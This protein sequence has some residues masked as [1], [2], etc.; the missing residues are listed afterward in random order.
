MSQANYKMKEKK[1]EH[2]DTAANQDDHNNYLSKLKNK[3]QVGM[4]G[5]VKKVTEE[6]TEVKASQLTT[7]TFK[8]MTSRNSV[9]ALSQNN[10]MPVID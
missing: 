8:A 10:S 9:N 5:A 6:Y 1:E 2:K 4:M 7:H 3:F